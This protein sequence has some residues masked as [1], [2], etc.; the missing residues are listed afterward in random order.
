MNKPNEALETSTLVPHV[1]IKL[2]H[3]RQSQ[4]NGPID[5]YSFQE[6]VANS[7]DLRDH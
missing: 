7:H 3:L 1:N 5:E 6:N 2:L 4:I